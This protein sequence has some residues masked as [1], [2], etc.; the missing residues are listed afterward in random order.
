MDEL[1]FIFKGHLDFG[2]KRSLDNVLNMYD[3]KIDNHYKKD[4]QFIKEDIFDEEQFCLSFPRSFVLR[5][6][7]KNFG[8]NSSL[9][10]YLSEFAITGQLEM[11]MIEERQVIDYKLVEPQGD[12]AAI[13][14]YTKGKLLSVSEGKTEEALAALN[15][16]IQKYEKHAQAYERRAYVSTML[17]KYHD[18]IRDY[19]KSINI[20]A[21]APDPYYGR[22]LVHKIQENY[23]EAADDFDTSIKR[24]IPLQPIHWKSRR[25]KAECLM[26]IEKFSDASQELK[27][28]TLRGFKEDNPNFKYRKKA[29]FDYG[30]CQ[31]KLGNFKEAVDL[32][33]KSFEIESGKYAPLDEE[34]LY[35]RGMARHKAGLPDFAKDLK[36]A[37]KAGIKEAAD[38]LADAKS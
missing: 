15:S 20:Y 3:W 38:A 9:L 31:Y 1:K 36:K 24:S 16:A 22:G 32:F 21:G 29:F 33:D 6:T 18:A 5:G 26:E 12:R 10:Q 14:S 13:S 17:K 25:R 37:A 28:F 19:T 35:R 11:W 23:Q 27:F 34:L 30:M 2:N 8:A 7:K 4:V